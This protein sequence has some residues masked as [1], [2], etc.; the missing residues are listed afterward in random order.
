M[1]IQFLDREKEQEEIKE[2]LESKKSELFILYGRRRVGKTE[3]ALHATKNKKRIYYL[4]VG[5]N[6]LERFYSVCMNFDREAANLKKDWEVLFDFLKNRAEVIIIDEFQNLIHE[7]RNILPLFQ[8]I[9]DVVLKG[10]KLKLFLLGSSVSI[11]TSKV[12][13]YKSPLYGRRT[14]SIRLKP[15]SFFDLHKFFPKE[16]IEKLVE[17]YG[18]ADGVPF[19][20]VKI[21]IELWKWFDKEINQ[22]KSFLRDE[23][24][25]LMKYEFA[26]S[27]TY[28]LILEAIANGKTKINEIKDFTNFKRTDI[29][30]YLKNLIDVGFL[31][32]AVPVTENIKSRH[33]R[34]FISD[35]F[36]K[37]WF[38]FIYPNLSSIEEGV[39]N[40]SLIKADYNSYLGFVFEN[41][42]K[43]FL[44]KNMPINF[45]RLDRQWGTVPKATKGGNTYEID[46]VGID[47][48]TKEVL[49]IGCKWS[50]LKEKEARKV[51]KELKEK[52]KFVEWERKKEYFGL[53]GKKVLG[54]E[55]LRKEGW[56]VWD[57]ED[58]EKMILQKL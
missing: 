39:F 27:G 56:F 57:L 9:V 8:S 23:I 29:T 40:T 51:L 21:D 6:N 35:N 18:F 14:A 28:K 20:L 19:Y 43:Q 48:K 30:P 1:I 4:A 26:D 54:K 42:A 3:L 58:L 5:E 38:R 11:I 25:F 33:G 34:Y 55:K 47:D 50:D 22:E 31:K 44:I 17:I 53:I 46:L 10:S 49:F 45:T 41:I 37:F 32:R 2:I 13:S 16:P 52:S 7:D 36:L 15:V 24:D 12:L